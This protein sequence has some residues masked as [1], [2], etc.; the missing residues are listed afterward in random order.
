[1]RLT[2][3][4]FCLA[5]Y[6]LPSWYNFEVKFDGMERLTTMKLERLIILTCF[7][8]SLVC[9]AVPA[10]DFHAI[11]ESTIKEAVRFVAPSVVRIDIVGGFQSTKGAAQGPTSGIVIS[12]DGYLLSSLFRFEEDPASIIVRFA[13]GE[14]AVAQMVARDFSRKVVLLKCDA[15]QKLKPI[16]LLD[17]QKLFVGQTTIAIGRVY[18]TNMPNVSVG[19]LS[20]KNRIWDRAVQTD[21]KISPS[22]FGGPLISLTGEVIGLLTPMEPG[23]ESANGGVQWYDSGIGFAVGLDAILANLSS[24]KSGNDLKRGMVGI[25]F[26][27]SNQYADPAEISV[28][29]EGGPAAKAGLQSGDMIVEVAGRAIDRQASFKHAVGSYYAGETVE[30]TINR[31]GESKKVS[32]TLTDKIA[33]FSRPFLGILA[34]DHPDDGVEINYVIAGS[35]AQKAGLQ[36]GLRIVEVNGKLFADQDSFDDLLVRTEIGE[37]VELTIVSKSKTDKINIVP[38][39][40]SCDLIDVP[41]TSAEEAKIVDLA[42]AE[43][44]NKC[45][46]IVPT[47]AD[48]SPSVLV[49]LNQ[50]GALDKKRFVDDWKSVC[51]AHNVV[52]VVPQSS[53]DKKW[54]K[55]EA[56]L[57]VKLLGVLKNQTD[58]DQR[59]VAIAGVKSGGAMALL[60]CMAS[61]ETFCGIAMLDTPLPAAPPR[62]RAS[63]SN[64]LSILLGTSTQFPGDNQSAVDQL[65]DAKF[66]VLV[67]NEGPGKTSAW[68]EQLLR[69]VRTLDRF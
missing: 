44:E 53:D 14:K 1:M 43:F 64:R 4:E 50:P 20:A 2:R 18:D 58:Y 32:V 29:F 21:A 17:P 36:S 40:A 26:K 49:F 5:R 46:A 9:S 45:F 57:M 25:G 55:T 69:W 30:M 41:V 8:S 33:P 65:H 11:E 68:A 10:Q 16:S 31:D 39:A 24:L 52:L 66:P 61:R 19:I 22:N 51:I 13:D 63:A 62:L 6:E 60:S 3:Y 54:D 47:G 37:K 23:D 35:P 34:D 27:G 42:V 7:V 15:K 67:L 48:N 38:A 56:D 12:E 28:C 59:Q